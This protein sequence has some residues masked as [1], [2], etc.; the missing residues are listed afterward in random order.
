LPEPECSCRPCESLPR[1]AFPA[2]R[3]LHECRFVTNRH[4]TEPSSD[5][6]VRSVQREHNH[7]ASHRHRTVRP[8]CSSHRSRPQRSCIA[9]MRSWV[10]VGLSAVS[11][12]VIGCSPRNDSVPRG[13]PVPGTSAFVDDHTVSPLHVGQYIG[14]L[15]KVGGGCHGR[16]GTS[17][18]AS[19]DVA[20]RVDKSCRVFVSSITASG[21]EESPPPRG[22]TFVPASP[23]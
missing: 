20:L 16:A 17:S 6:R 11:V 14:R 15:K 1:S 12:I 21:G 2:C 18:S 23:G 8:G 10:A 4:R 19:W 3:Y 22:G 7:N 9:L 13:S 5:R